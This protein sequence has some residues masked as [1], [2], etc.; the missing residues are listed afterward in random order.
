MREGEPGDDYVL[1]DDGRRSRSARAA[2]SSRTLG[3]GAG[4]GEIALIHDV[5]RTA[6]VRAI[7]PV[8]G[9]SLDR[10][11]FLEA[12]TGHAASRAAARVDAP[13]SGSPRTRGPAVH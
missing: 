2:A 11:A 12:V 1:I 3:P 6:S 8:D 9:F 4:V 13:T 5:P 7:E 10:D